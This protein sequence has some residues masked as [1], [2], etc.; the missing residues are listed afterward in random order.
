MSAK[1]ITYSATRARTMQDLQATFRQWGVGHGDEAAMAELNAAIE[2]V[3]A[4]KR[5]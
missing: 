3:R 5:P 1:K 2:R 4:D